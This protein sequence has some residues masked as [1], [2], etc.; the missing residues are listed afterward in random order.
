MSARDEM[1]LAAVDGKPTSSTGWRR[2]ACPFCPTKLGKEDRKD[3]LGVHNGGGWHCFRCGT[4]GRLKSGEVSDDELFAGSDEDWTTGEP[5][6][7]ELL[8]D[9]EGMSAL[10]LERPRDYL[11][12]TR[13]LDARVLRRARVGYCSSGRY[14][15]RIVI[16]IF[17]PGDARWRGF[18]TRIVP[19]ATAKAAYLYAKD[20][21]RG[22]FLYNE[23]VLGEETDAPAIVVEGCLDALA[24]WPDGVAVLGKTSGDQ[25]DILA[26]AR[27]PIAVA[28]DPDVSE[29]DGAIL[30]NVLRTKGRSA[31]FVR[32][33]SGCDPDE[34][35]ADWLRAEA[36]ERIER[37][38]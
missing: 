21:P 30:A 32:L 22:T 16:P 12:K 19:P 18:V 11:T 9:E 24:L 35:D 33:P 36:R 3:C 1:V 13:K 14:K 34:V 10:S 37:E 8:F 38:L 31:G 29:N 6:S 5:E 23:E 4:K 15:N 20:M 17:R 26:A 27:R 28:F 25:V 2:G 7:F